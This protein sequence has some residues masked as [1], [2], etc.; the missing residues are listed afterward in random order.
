MHHIIYLSQATNPVSDRQLQ[1]ILL[2]SRRYNSE[3]NITG[4]LLYGNQHFMQ[5][6]EGEQQAIA[7]L[8]EKIKRDARHGSVVTFANKA[9]EQRTFAEWSMAF[10]PASAEQ[11][12]YLM[13]FA[14]LT[15]FTAEQLNMTTTDARLLQ[16]LQSFVLP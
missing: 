7:A 3:R 1:E 9:I 8:Y 16:T 5:V 4:L 10:K 6:L 14:P 2:Q 15:P 12:A 13:D 11:L